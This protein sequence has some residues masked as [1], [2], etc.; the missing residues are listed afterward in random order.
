MAI[1]FDAA[2][3]RI[4]LDSAAA[5][6]SD[7]F[8]RWMD[9]AAT[10]DNAKYGEVL[11]QVGGEDLGGGLSIPPYFFLQ[12]GWRVRPMEVN[13]TLSIT[14]N[15][16]V[17]GGG[18]PVVP[19]L[20]TFNVLTKLVVPVQAQGISTGGGS[21]PASIADQV[22]IELAAELLRI[23]DLAKVHGLVPGTDLV[24]TPTSRTAGDVAQTITEAGS[25]VTV[26]RA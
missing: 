10:A 19:T 5:S 21:S 24:V 20:G 3:K 4:V 1:F 17:D 25:T 14:G 15:L 8:S 6:A 26:S 11:S 9:W 7:I 16:F 2:N 18:D 23:M 22:R 13:Q 12:N